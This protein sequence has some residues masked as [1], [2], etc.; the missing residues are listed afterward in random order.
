MGNFTALSVLVVATEREEAYC[1]SQ[2][3]PSR[4]QHLI[5]PDGRVVIERE[6]SDAS[7]K[8]D[9]V[10]KASRRGNISSFTAQIAKVQHRDIVD[11]FDDLLERLPAIPERYKDKE[12]GSIS[13]VDVL[14]AM[15]WAESEWLSVMRT[16]VAH[17]WRHTQMLD[18][19]MYD[20]VESFHKLQTRALTHSSLG[21]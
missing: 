21:T 9:C 14:F 19:D 7:I 20:L 16:T 3:S 6:H 2:H 5:A 4:R 17:C 11:H 12:L 13:N 8:Y 10:F 18:D 15:Q 1:W